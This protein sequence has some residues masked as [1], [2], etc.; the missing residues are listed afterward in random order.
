MD[1]SKE[2]SDL[3][4]TLTRKRTAAGLI[5]AELGKLARVSTRT[6]SRCETGLTTSLRTYH[7]LISVLDGY[8]PEEQDVNK[9]IELF[10]SARAMLER[11][12]RY[13]DISLIPV[14][15]EILKL[16]NIK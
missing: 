6:V 5:Q 4:A 10:N 7:H 9:N 13:K 11:A 14:A 12:H 8:L 2:I 3:S 16:V 15:L 1:L